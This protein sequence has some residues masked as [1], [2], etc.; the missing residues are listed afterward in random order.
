MRGLTPPENKTTLSP[1]NSATTARILI[2]LLAATP[3]EFRIDGNELLRRRPMEWIVEPLRRAGAHIV[4]ANVPR[5]ATCA[6]SRI[7]D[8]RHQP[9]G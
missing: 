3:G 6:C 7:E 5:P 4:Y 9:S 8:W 2:G 1:G